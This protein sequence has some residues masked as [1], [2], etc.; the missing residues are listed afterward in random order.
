MILKI[1]ILS[2]L[3]AFGAFAHEGHETPGALPPAPHGGKVGAAECD[4]SMKDHS[5]E[6]Y[7]VFL[8]AKVV[9]SVLNI[10][11]LGLGGDSTKVFKTLK[12]SD[13]LKISELKIEFPRS[14]K[15]LNVPAKTLEDRW[16]VA[17]ENATERRFL[18]HAK[19]LDNHGGNSET[20][21]AKIQV[22]R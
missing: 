12:P 16:E 2:G 19:V 6:K 4:P 11:P 17:L 20:K 10:Y 8:E 13:T 22:E 15:T 7:E 21:T 5:K 1:S 3:L 9:G 18:V 14:K